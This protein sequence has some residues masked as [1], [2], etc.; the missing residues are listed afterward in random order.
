MIY[1]KTAE[2]KI[3]IDRSQHT[4]C[5]TTA[6]FQQRNIFKALNHKHNL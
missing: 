1:F 2:L 3:E 6:L 4:K 5:N